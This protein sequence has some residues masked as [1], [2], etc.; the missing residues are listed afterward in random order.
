MPV[1]AVG[2]VVQTAHHDRTAGRATGGRGK[3]IEKKGSVF[4]EGVDSRGLG[5]FVSITS[6]GGGFVVGDEE[7]NVFLC[8]EKGTCEEQ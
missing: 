6:E 7:D 5:N 3:S 4:G 2:V 1:L 8:S